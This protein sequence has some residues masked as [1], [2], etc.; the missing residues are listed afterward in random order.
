MPAAWSC[1]S[2][3]RPAPAMRGSGTPAITWSPTSRTR[4]SLDRLEKTGGSLL[5]SFRDYRTLLSNSDFSVIRDRLL[6][7][8]T[9]RLESDPELAVRILEFIAQHGVP[10]AHDTERRLAEKKR[11]LR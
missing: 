7:R 6:L 8:N 3:N 4:R 9:A 5:D 1:A 10:L 2:C 11:S